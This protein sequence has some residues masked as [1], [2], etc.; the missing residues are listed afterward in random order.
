MTAVCVQVQFKSGQW[1]GRGNFRNKWHGFITQS[2]SYANSARFSLFAVGLRE[3][4]VHSMILGGGMT[5]RGQCHR[6]T[7]LPTTYTIAWDRIGSPVL[8]DESTR[9]AWEHFLRNLKQ[10]VGHNKKRGCGYLETRISPYLETILDHVFQEI[11]GWKKGRE[12]EWRDLL[13]DSFCIKRAQGCHPFP[14]AFRVRKPPSMSGL[15]S[16]FLFPWLLARGLWLLVVFS[17]VLVPL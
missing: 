16:M 2:C 4:K 10:R 14:E 17:K 9:T 8:E 1:E 7:G 3:N 12:G 11:P 15:S 6:K 5:W 13:L